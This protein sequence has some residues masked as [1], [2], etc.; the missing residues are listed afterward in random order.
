MKKRTNGFETSGQHKPLKSSFNFNG[1]LSSDSDSDFE[2][3]PPFNNFVCN[4]KTN[5][6]KVKPVKATIKLCSDSEDDD[7]KERCVD[8]KYCVD[9]SMRVSR[10][11]SESPELTIPGIPA[12]CN[13]RPSVESY[14]YTVVKNRESVAS[15]TIDLDQLGEPL[16]ESTRIHRRSSA[17]FK[18]IFGKINELD[19]IENADN[20]LPSSEDLKNDI[21]G[22]DI[23][24]R[25][26]KIKT[27][28]VKGKRVGEDLDVIHDENELYVT[29]VEMLDVTATTNENENTEDFKADKFQASGR[30]KKQSTVKSKKTATKN[31]LIVSDNGDSEDEIVDIIEV[32]DAGTQTEDVESEHCAITGCKEK[33]E[34]MYDHETVLESI[35]DDKIEGIVYEQKTEVISEKDEVGKDTSV[36]IEHSDSINY[37]SE[38]IENEKL[39]EINN[40]NE[41]TDISV[42]ENSVEEVYA[43]STNISYTIADKQYQNQTRNN[44]ISEIREGNNLYN[45][46]TRV[47]VDN[48]LL[49]KDYVQRTLV[50]NEVEHDLTEIDGYSDDVS[51]KATEQCMIDEDASEPESM[52]LQSDQNEA[53]KN[54]DQCYINDNS[55]SELSEFEVVDVG[56]QTEASRD[57]D[58]DLDD[59]DKADE[60][61]DVSKTKEA[62]DSQSGKSETDPKE[63]KC[64]KKAIQFKRDNNSVQSDSFGEGNAVSDDEPDQDN[65]SSSSG[66]VE[67]D[68]QDS[69]DEEPNKAVEVSF[70]FIAKEGKKKNKFNTENSQV[71]T[72]VSTEQS[73]R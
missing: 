49:I 10:K 11:V 56:T 29:A 47:S 13:G 69:T 2:N 70:A 35:S 27:K 63:E 71:S 18:Q 50:T 72:A 28:G 3:K 55:S 60:S 73:W 62:D 24:M 48:V 45:D 64:R 16:V 51:S 17:S 12:S 38:D 53:D 9:D 1:I 42:K 30:K 66:E 36:L 23:N 57:Q 44:E 68:S 39:S 41:H 37:E 54:E 59:T 20:T 40:C 32:V 65:T 25:G 34:T 31:I 6:K 7:E 58:I 43:D 26:L 21:E 4:G 19:D 46:E 52:E 22:L 14:N 61:N 5:Q 15:M 8:S 33:L 67:N